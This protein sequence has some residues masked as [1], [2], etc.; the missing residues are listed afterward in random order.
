M[1]ANPPAHPARGIPV[2]AT[3]A[4]ATAA[5][6]TAAPA[7]AAPATAAPAE[8]A[9]RQSPP[10]QGAYRLG[11]VLYQRGRLDEA[12]TAWRLAAAKQHPDA[13][14]RLAELLE[15]TGGTDARS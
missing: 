13:A 14:S 9:P 7:T 3:A 10:G 8:P 15:E 4:P 1:I 2:P 5:P 12:A 6:A 11:Q